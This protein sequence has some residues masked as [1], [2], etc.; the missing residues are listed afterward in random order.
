MTTREVATTPTT[1]EA[2]TEPPREPRLRERRGFAQFSV[3]TRITVVISLLTA[4]AM[5]ASGLLVYALESARIEREVN[6]QIDQEIAEFRALRQDPA[7][8]E[9]FTEVERILRVFLTRNVPDDDEMLV[10]YVEGVRPLRTANRYGEQI[11]DDSVYLDAVASVRDEGGTSV[12]DSDEF[13]EVWVTLVPV[14]NNEE[15]GALAIVNFLDDEHSELNRTLQTYAIVALLSL[16]II[17]AIAAFQSGRLLAPLRVLRRTADEISATDLSR[18]IPETGNDDITALT[19]TVNG[20]LDRLE[21][22][23]VGQRRFLD[24]AG[25]EL[26][27]PLTVLRG[28]LELLDATDP[29]EVAETRTLLLDEVDRM[30]GLVGDLI[31]LAKA[32]RPDFLTPTSVSLERLTHTL[33]AKARGLGDR[34]WELDAAGEGLVTMDEQ[35]I[36]QAVLQL[37]DNA[38]KHSGDGDVIAV[39][40]SYDGSGGRLWVRD[41]GDGVPEEDRV[42]IFGRFERGQTREGDEGFG[43]GLSIVSAIVEGHGGAVWVEDAKPHGSKFVIALPGSEDTW[44]AS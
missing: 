44:P 13:G 12:I 20:M 26:R 16:G 29:E 30:S 21:A 17:T 39:G 7:T 8:G 5:A 19:H 10:G 23:F 1:P 35:R 3:R 18:R 27:T 24:A 32:K 22:A 43:L 2:T 25:H 11:L 15:S 31:V 14:G 33:L 37:V 4:V 38:V 9:P 34:T 36:T 41:A 6:E 42:R 40:S 28:H